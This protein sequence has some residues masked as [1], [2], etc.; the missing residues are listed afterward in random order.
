M[1]NSDNTLVELGFSRLAALVVDVYKVKPN[2]NMDTML[3]R[4]GKL[5]EE[6]G[7]VM[8]AFLGATSPHNFKAK[9]WADFHEELV[10]C[11]IVSID[12]CLT[13]T[14]GIRAED[15]LSLVLGYVKNLRNIH[16]SDGD[17]RLPNEDDFLKRF[18][19]HAPKAISKLTDEL[20]ICLAD[21]HI[22]RDHL[23]NEQ[24]QIFFW[25][26]QFVMTQTPG[27]RDTSFVSLADI[28]ALKMDKWVNGK[29]GEDA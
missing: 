2:R 28:A 14:P 20:V 22:A 6:T 13:P 1:S 16:F 15:R 26:F 19:L 4:I 9:S 8:E 11:L 3:R 29:K 17:L 24:R 12:L 5:T 27:R 25:F 23:W 7:E 21:K 10:D 18:L